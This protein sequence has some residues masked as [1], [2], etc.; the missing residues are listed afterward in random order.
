MSPRIGLG[1]DI[2]AFSAEPDRPLVL[3]GVKVPAS[4]GLAGHSDADVIA[5]AVADALL[6]AAGMGDLGDHFPDDDPRWKGADSMVL[7]AQVV[8]EVTGGAAAAASIV[9]VDCAVLLAAPR[10]SPYRATIQQNLSEACGAPVTV[11]AKNPEGLG[12]PGRGEGVACWA[13]ALIDVGER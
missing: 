11:K 7:L 9:N 4:R 3:G 12:A 10:L 8:S 2:H 6:G 5:H 1:F 13:V